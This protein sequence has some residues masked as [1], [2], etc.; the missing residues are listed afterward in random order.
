MVDF[1]FVSGTCHSKVNWPNS[2][3]GVFDKLSVVL[4]L[5]HPSVKLMNIVPAQHAG[6]AP[7]NSSLDLSIDWFRVAVKHSSRYG[8]LSG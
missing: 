5:V 8:G 6:N 4:Y 2:V 7:A 3:E 1:E